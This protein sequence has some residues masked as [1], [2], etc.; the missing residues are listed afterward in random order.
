MA[1]AQAVPELL[2][3]LRALPDKLDRAAAQSGQIAFDSASWCGGVYS[4]LATTFGPAT[5]TSPGSILESAM[6][7][8]ALQSG[9]AYAILGRDFGIYCH[10]LPFLPSAQLF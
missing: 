5:P 8:Y 7:E 2:L 4:G 6:V 10:S 3:A 1:V 9:Q